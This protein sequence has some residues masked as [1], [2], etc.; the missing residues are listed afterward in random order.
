M[1]IIP[2]T[3]RA[4]NDFVERRHRHSGRSSNDSGKFA[5]GLE[6]AGALVGVAIVGRPIA[7]MIQH[8]DQ[9]FPAELLRLCTSPACPKGG[10]SKLYSRAR[11]LWQLMGGTHF[12]TYTLRREGGETMRAVG[13][14]AEDAVEVAGRQWD[15]PA[16]R[17]RRKVIHD[18][19]KL[20]WSEEL[21]PVAI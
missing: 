2:M 18:E 15:R 20:R 6:H 5:I 12:H 16:R 7:R 21:P 19:P 17:R 10:G 4:A 13:F 1:R 14:K 11:R 3:L 9:E 8:S